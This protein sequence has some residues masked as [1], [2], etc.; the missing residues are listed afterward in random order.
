MKDKLLLLF[1]GLLAGAVF[2]GC[3]WGFGRM[4]NWINAQSSSLPVSPYLFKAGL[5]AVI[6][7][8]LVGIGKIFLFFN[9][10]NSYQQAAK[11]FSPELLNSIYKAPLAQAV[12]EQREDKLDGLRFLPEPTRLECV[13]APVHEGITPLH[14]AAGLGRKKFCVRLLRYGADIQLRDQAGLTPLDYAARFGRQ[15]TWRFLQTYTHKARP[16]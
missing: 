5:L 6:G 11:I 3:I 10:K 2:V 1:W 8:V 16:H 13:N 12:V 15:D 14:I 9:R 4:V 7:V